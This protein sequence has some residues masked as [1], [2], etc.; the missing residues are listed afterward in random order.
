MKKLLLLSVILIFACS[1]DD[2]TN[3][4]NTETFLERYSDIVWQSTD[5]EEL[6]L[7]FNLN[8]FIQKD[9]ECLVYIWD[10]ENPNSGATWNLLENNYDNI[11][12]SKEEDG[13]IDFTSIITISEDENTLSEYI[14]DEETFTAQRTNLTHPC[15]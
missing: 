2:S 6:R 1:S 14:S 15:N 7:S 9:E 12:I 13:T 10:E 3:D 8:G 4:N 11:I 5:S